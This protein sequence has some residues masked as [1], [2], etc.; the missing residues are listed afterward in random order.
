[1]AGNGDNFNIPVPQIKN[2]AVINRK[3]FHWLGNSKE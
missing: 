1:M 3:G 2:K